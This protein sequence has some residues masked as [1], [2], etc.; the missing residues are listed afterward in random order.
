[1]IGNSMKI[2]NCCIF[3]LMCLSSAFGS[4]AFYDRGE[5]LRNL[6]ASHVVEQ[7]I[8]NKLAPLQEQIATQKKILRKEQG[9]L[10]TTFGKLSASDRQLK[11]NNIAQ[12]F[13]TLQNSQNM[14]QHKLQELRTKLYQP[15]IN[16]LQQALVDV[17][18]MESHDA[19]IDIKNPGIIYYN[20]NS[21]ITWLL[22]ARVKDYF[23]RD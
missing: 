17:A 15:I 4:V 18:K 1:M 2:C 13:G 3:T 11:K 10:Q 6:P 9:D 8:Q 22:I 23:K 19:I 12:L 20:K 21:D 14:V 16:Q 5:V 7:Q